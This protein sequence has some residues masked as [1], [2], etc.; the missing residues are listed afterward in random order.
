MLDFMCFIGDSGLN[1][2]SI[3]KPAEGRTGQAEASGSHALA[4]FEGLGQGTQAGVP[5]QKQGS[6]G[7][8]S[9]GL[10][11]VNPQQENV[12]PPY[13]QAATAANASV[14][15][16]KPVRRSAILNFRCMLILYMM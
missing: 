10:T 14:V 7:S 8:R 11:R 15:A 2:P 1:S 13:D 4:A 16:A 3:G 6:R 5:S 9:G 12:I